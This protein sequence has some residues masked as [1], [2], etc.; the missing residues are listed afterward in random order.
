MGVT[1]TVIGFVGTI[2]GFMIVLNGISS[3]IEGGRL[4]GVEELGLLLGSSLGGFSTAAYSTL[5]GA[6]G[7]LI[8]YVIDGILSRRAEAV[9]EEISDVLSRHV[10][11]LLRGLT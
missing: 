11:P 9:F 1:V 8:I 7:G 2:V 5:A 4:S 6:A 3:Q 10:E